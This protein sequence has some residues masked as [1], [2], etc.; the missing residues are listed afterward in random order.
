[1]Q[2]L[3]WDDREAWSLLA[4]PEPNPLKSFGGVT[5]T[6]FNRFFEEVAEPQEWR[7][8]FGVSR[9]WP[10]DVS[11]YESRRKVPVGRTH[12]EPEGARELSADI[13]QILGMRTSEDYDAWLAPSLYKTRMLPMPPSMARYALT[14]YASS[15]VRY[16]PQMFD[17]ASHPEQAYLF[18]AV[19]REV[20]LPMLTDVLAAIVGQPVYFYST[21]G[22]RL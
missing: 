13:R 8:H 11:F 17:P 6:L 15:L 22:L 20:A 12:D 2:M 16:K 18:D 9:R 21:G 3:A 7:D 14:Y 10:W 5:A 19:S 1:M 4:C